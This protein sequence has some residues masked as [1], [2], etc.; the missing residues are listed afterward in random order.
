MNGSETSGVVLNQRMYKGW[1]TWQIQSGPLELILV[2]L[3]GGR[4]MS[5]QWRGHDLSFTQPEREGHVEEVSH[6]RDVRA[7]KRE[8]GFPLWGGEKTWLSPQHRWPDGLPFLDLDSGRYTLQVEQAG[9]EG[10]VVRMT[11]PV[12]RE[13]GVQITRTITVAAGSTE[14][15]V[16]HQIHNATST[17]VEWGIWDVA[18]VVRPGRVYLPRHRSSSFPQGVKTFSEEGESTLM[19]NSVVNELGSLAVIT[20]EHARKFKFGVDGQSQAA[21]SKEKGWM[22]GVLD[23]AGVG[24]V[25]YRKRVP[26]YEGQQYGHDCLAEV[27]NSDV[28]PYFEMEIHGPLVRLKPGQSFQLEEQQALCE[29]VDWPETEEEVVA[30]VT[31]PWR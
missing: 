10:V 4:V 7:R 25:G 3:V 24:L 27:F 2:P 18:M 1:E 8:I 20:C 11:S 28:Y 29:L 13:T 31:D 16:A 15:T 17:D 6:V 19:R 22:L 23:V 12:C 5:M 30:L 14:W 26:V 21:G 9:P